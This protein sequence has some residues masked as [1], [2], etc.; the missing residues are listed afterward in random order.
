MKGLTSIRSVLR[1]HPDV[2]RKG[3]WKELPVPEHFRSQRPACR[4]IKRFLLNRE[5]SV[6]VYNVETEWGTVEHLLV[7]PHSEA[8]IRNWYKLQE[9]K[10][11]V[12]GPG[13]VAVEVFP[14]EDD[15]HDAGFA[16]YHL[17]VLPE[18]FELP[19]GMHLPGG[20]ML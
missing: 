15:L 1:E 16:I 3:V 10:N 20:G 14:R 2:K 12:V 7:R 11:A 5:V 9:V 8:P 13:R 18:D 17:W 19:F 4:K 6:Q